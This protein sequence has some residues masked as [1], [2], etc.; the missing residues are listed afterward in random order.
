MSLGN[1]RG[2]AHDAGRTA[3]APNSLG[4]GA[5]PGRERRWVVGMH[6]CCDMAL[7]FGSLAAATFAGGLVHA[8]SYPLGACSVTDVW[9]GTEFAQHARTGDVLITSS[10]RSGRGAGICLA[11]RSPWTHCGVYLEPGI[12]NGRPL[13]ASELSA[14]GDNGVRIR[15]VAELVEHNGC[16]V[17]RHFANESPQLARSTI[18]AA[19]GLAGRLGYSTDPLALLA[20]TFRG[21]LPAWTDAVHGQ[22]GLTCAQVVAVVLTDAGVLTLDRDVSRFVPATFADDGDAAWRAVPARGRL[23]VGWPSRAVDVRKI[24]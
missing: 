3:D 6:L 17:C 20:C 13:V 1:G 22:A 8:V 11:T 23:V 15:P 14:D 12:A 18:A 2:R 5:A 7:F 24:K 4:V 16:F 21:A 19:E 9:T 10:S